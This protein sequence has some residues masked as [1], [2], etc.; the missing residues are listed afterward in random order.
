MTGGTGGVRPRK[1]LWPDVA[2]GGRRKRVFDFL[3][4]VGILLFAWP[5]MLSIALAIK[6][7]SKGPA[8]FQQERIGHGG[9]KFGCLKF[10]SMVADAPDRLAQ[11]L[12]A[13]PDAA[14]EWAETRKLRNDPRITV[15][16][17]LLRRSS[18]DELPQLINVVRGDMSLVGPRPVQSDE[19]SR[20]GMQRVHYLRTRPGM[21]GLW[22]VSGRSDTGYAERINLDKRYALQ[23]SMRR[24]AEILL[25]TIPAVVLQRGA[26]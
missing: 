6:L 26:V 15:I 22:Q 7:T 1:R 12:A 17:H 4:A 23:W 8:L 2:L 10:R 18:F 16:G 25:K 21:T 13:D 14:R 3:G 5:L 9:R 24:D 20:Y 11:C 19:L